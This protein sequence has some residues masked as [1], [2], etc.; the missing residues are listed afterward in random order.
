MPPTGR[1]KIFENGIW[2]YAVFGPSGAVGPAGPTGPTGASGPTGPTGASGANLALAAVQ[3]TNF[4]AVANTLVPVDTTANPV[5]I[6]LPNAPLDQVVIAV[7][8]IILGAGHLVTVAT[9]GADVFNKAGGST[10]L[11]LPLLNQGLWATYD[12][13]NKI[14]TVIADDLPLSQLDARYDAAGVAATETTRATAAEALL[15]PKA[16]PALTGIPVAPTATGGTN[17]TQ[18]ATTAFVTTAVSSIDDVLQYST[19][20]AFPATGTPGIIYIAED[21]EYL[22]R[23]SGSA[24]VQ[25]GGTPSAVSSVFGRTGAVVATSGDYTAAQVTGALQSSNNLSD[26]ADAGSSR[27]NLS[28]SALSS[29]AA[30]AV[31]NINIA[32]P[33]ATLDGY[34]LQTN[35]EVLLTAQTTASQNGIWIWNGATSALTRPNEF[36]TGGIVKRGRLCSVINGTV[37]ADTLWVLNSTAAGLTIGTTAQT[38]VQGN[39]TTYLKVSNNLSD[40]ASAS[41]AR[42]NLG[43]GTIATLSAVSL[44][45]N[46][47]GT[48]PIANGGTGSTSTSQNYAFIGPTSGSGAPSFRAIVA[49]DIPTLNQNTTGTAGNVTGTVAIANGGTG[50]TTGSAALTALGGMATATYDAANIAQQVLGTSAAQTASNKRITR[51]VGSTTSSATPTIN[52]DNYDVYEL[53]AQAAAVTSFTTNLTGTPVDGDALIICITDNGTSQT[54]AWGSKFES[55]NNASLPTATIASTLLTIGF[56]WNT[57]TSKWHCVASSGV[58]T[59]SQGPNNQTIINYGFQYERTA[60][61]DAAYSILTTDCIVA[62]TALTAARTATLPSA[63]GVAGQVYYIKDESGNAGTYNITLATTSSQTIDGSSTKVISANYGVQRVYSNG[64]NWFTF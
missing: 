1:L 22:Y 50:Q 62:Y 17:T 45:T 37:Y 49:G 3:T 26:V 38:W 23:W 30:V 63:V 20:S 7:K 10:S 4:N 33:G 35:D 54:L 13:A 32:S 59:I 53:T 12:A 36:P 61:S 8:L 25:V 34:S 56:R 29:A 55:S 2:N 11:T 47:S 40:L 27:F 44:T 5:T 18:I 28:T 48:L 15:A 24:Y 19:L 64:S 57:T 60:V 6:T 9:A 43:L 41:T 39:S 52:T 42:T 58:Q 14:W 31:A 16:S 46:V 51:R 21:T